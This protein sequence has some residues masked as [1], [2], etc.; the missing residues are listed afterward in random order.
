MIIVGLDPGIA[1]C[2]FGIINTDI[3]SLFVRCGCITTLKSLPDEDRLLQLANDLQV[4]LKQEKVEHAVIEKIY[5]GANTKTAIQVAQAR[6]VLLYATRKLHLSITELTPLQIKSQ[7]TGYGRATKEQIQHVLT[8]RLKL[9]QIPK[10]DDAA[11]ALACAL[12]VADSNIQS[13]MIT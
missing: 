9:D 2:G 1:R 13:K 10:P 3:A 4:L 6:G 8:Q 7:L 5:F 11:D 12:C